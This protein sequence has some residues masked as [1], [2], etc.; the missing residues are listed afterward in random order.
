MYYSNQLGTIDSL[1]A[2]RGA[3]VALRT[4]KTHPCVCVGLWCFFAMCKLLNFVV[5]CGAHQVFDEI[6]LLW[7]SL[8][9]RE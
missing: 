7:F 5:S 2:V 1:T 9:L 6:T 8:N 4:V 3:N